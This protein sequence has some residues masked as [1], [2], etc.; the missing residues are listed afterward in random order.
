[1]CPCGM[2]VEVHDRYVL[3]STTGPIEHVSGI[4]AVG[5]RFSCSIDYMES[6][7]FRLTD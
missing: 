5:H 4:C 2:P 7:E 6:E 3:E 1:M